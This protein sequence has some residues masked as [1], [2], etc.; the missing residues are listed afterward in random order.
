MKNMECVIFIDS[1]LIIFI[2]DST[3][4]V[5]GSEDGLFVV[6]LSKDRKLPDFLFLKRDDVCY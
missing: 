4:I 6:D 3:K 2:T 1:F 5:L